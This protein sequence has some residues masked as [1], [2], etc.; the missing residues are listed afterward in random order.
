[1][2]EL[3]DSPF[4]GNAYKCRLL[5]HKLGLPYRRTVVD[6][7]R[8]ESRTP[9]FLARN[10]NG[11]VPLLLLEDGTHLAESNAILCWLAKGTAWLPEDRLEFAQVMQWLFFEQYSHEP[12]IATV[13]Y[14]LTHGFEITPL[15]AQLIEIKR[16]QGHAALGVMEG[17]LASR[18]F[19]VGARPT[20]ADMALYAYTHVAEEGGF[21]LKDYPHVRA[22][23][24]RV[25]ADTPH[26]AITD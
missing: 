18:P 11:R 7:D 12:N 8:G 16:P 13:R 2:I 15:R 17:H 23:L 26:I 22:W 9:E 25:T 5:M 14:W 6:I 3:F 20:I 21:A 4:S 19:F 24:A 1:M 10:P